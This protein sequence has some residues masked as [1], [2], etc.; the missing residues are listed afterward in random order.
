MGSLYRPNISVHL[1]PQP[2]LETQVTFISS[3]AR[4]AGDGLNFPVSISPAIDVENA[5]GAFPMVIL[6]HFDTGASVSIIDVGLA[7]HMGLTPTGM[8]PIMTVG[9]LCEFPTY[10]IGLAFP[11]STL[12]PFAKLPIGSGQ[13]GFDINGDVSRSPNFGLLIGRDVM[14]RWS[15]FWNGPA[16]SVTIND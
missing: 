14:S 13:L 16:S 8:E 12:A 15:I 9:G 2:S 3:P 10:A 5:N 11:G 7:E 4:L 1:N 6:A